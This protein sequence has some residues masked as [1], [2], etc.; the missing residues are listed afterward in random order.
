VVRS[1]V[2]GGSQERPNIS[3]FNEKSA[4]RKISEIFG[5]FLIKVTKKRNSF[6]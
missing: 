6:V 1:Q 4:K 5:I 3:D 2:P